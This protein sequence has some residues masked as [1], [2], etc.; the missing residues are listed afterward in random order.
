MRELSDEVVVWNQ[1]AGFEFN[2]IEPVVTLLPIS[3]IIIL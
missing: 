3:L 1:K 2:Q